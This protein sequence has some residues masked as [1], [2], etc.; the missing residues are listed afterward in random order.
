MKKNY[1]RHLLIGCIFV[2]IYMLLVCLLYIAESFDPNASIKDFG[3]ALWYSFATLSTVGYGDVTPV[4]FLGRFIG[5]IFILLATGVI[6][7]LFGAVFSFVTGEAMPLLI[8]S[9]MRKRNWYYFADYG[10]EAHSLAENIHKEDGSAIIIFGQSSEELQEK[11]D[12]RCVFLN[13]SPARVVQ[14]KKNVGSKVKVFFMQE[15]DISKNTHSVSIPE[16]D[17]EVYARAVS[18]KDVMFGNINIFH[19]YDCCARQYWRQYPYD[20]KEK[21]IVMIGFGLYG[22]ALLERAIITNVVAMDQNTSYHIFGDG[23]QFMSMHPHLN[24]VFSID[25]ESEDRD[26]IIFHKDEWQKAY[27]LLRTADRIIICD[28]DDNVCWDTYWA[29]TRFYSV[30]GRVDIRSSKELKGI[31]YFGAYD[32]IFTSKQIVR[33]ELNNAAMAMNELYRNS[34]DHQTIAWEDLDDF[35]RQSKIA[36]ADHLLM[37]AR[38][39]MRNDDIHILTADICEKAYEIYSVERLN[40]NL[41][42]M[43][44]IIEHM[45]WRRFYVYYNWSYGEVRDD[46]KRQHPNI[47]DYEN[48]TEDQKSHNDFAWVLMGEIAEALRNKERC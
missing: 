23:N 48:L 45:R 10:P 37:K 28:D 1:K 39:L 13:V 41:T 33:T 38:I 47:Q 16:Q 29:L 36:A 15:N 30:E 21:R 27:E 18:G 19:I 43:F 6:V 17:V 42:D 32:Q 8:L 12:Y 34:T 35:L 2:G 40:K 11:P 24:E 31:N 7:A 5:I 22:Q 25:A 14:V 20:S 26:A 44:R 3:D 9:F 46:V 4:T